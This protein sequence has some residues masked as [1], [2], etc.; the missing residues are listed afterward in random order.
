MFDGDKYYPPPP[1]P[2]W[3]PPPGYKPGDPWYLWVSSDPTEEPPSSS[4]P[5]SDED[6]S[7]PQEEMTGSDEENT[8]GGERDEVTD[9][10]ELEIDTEEPP[11]LPEGYDED[12]LDEYISDDSA[13]EADSEDNLEHSEGGLVSKPMDGKVPANPM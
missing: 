9:A 5:S 13:V 6:G 12:G 1:P 2:P 4:A 11:Y 10:E 8:N 7:F 3:I